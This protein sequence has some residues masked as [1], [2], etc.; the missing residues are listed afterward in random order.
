[1]GDNFDP[2]ECIYNHESNM[3][4]LLNMLRQSQRYCNDIMCQTDPSN[5]LT[6]Q[7]GSSLATPV[8]FM[9]TWAVA[10]AG[11][12]AYRYFRNGQGSGK[13]DRFEVR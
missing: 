9:A 11:V 12:Y 13:P 5:P 6:D 4:R 10:M 2:C 7:S 1:M 8:L 3:Q